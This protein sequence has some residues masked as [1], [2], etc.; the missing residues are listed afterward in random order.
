MDLNKLYE[1]FYNHPDDWKFLYGRGNVIERNRSFYLFD[2]M[3]FFFAAD[4]F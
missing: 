4:Y 2:E 1:L 3:R